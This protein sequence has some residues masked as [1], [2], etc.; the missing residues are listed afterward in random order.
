MRESFESSGISFSEYTVLDWRNA[1]AAPALVRSA[2]LLILGG[3]IDQ[4]VGTE[5]AE[6]LASRITGA[7]KYIYEKFGHGAY[8]EAKD[9]QE[10]V[11]A[12]LEKETKL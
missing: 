11:L 8:E 2:Q 1:A 5:A 9:F 7:Q 6:R 10:R 12:F 3:G 4:I